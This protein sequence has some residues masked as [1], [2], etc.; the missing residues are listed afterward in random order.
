M[1]HDY[2]DKDAIFNSY[3]KDLAHDSTY[4]EIEIIEES[5]LGP[6]ILKNVEKVHE[7]I[8]SA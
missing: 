2:Y 1:G 6:D 3:M 5:A 7:Q 4:G 8:V